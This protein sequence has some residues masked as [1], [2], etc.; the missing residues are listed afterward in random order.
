MKKLN[1]PNYKNYL[2]SRDKT[3]MNMWRLELNYIFFIISRNSSVFSGIIYFRFVEISDHIGELCVG[4][5]W[6]TCFSLV[7]LFFVEVYKCGFWWVFRIFNVWDNVK[8]YV[9]I[10][11]CCLK[12]SQVMARLSSPSVLNLWNHS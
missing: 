3:V 10:P 12:L 2:R 4:S 11:K 5:I 9:V 6:V 8:S 7:L 1:K